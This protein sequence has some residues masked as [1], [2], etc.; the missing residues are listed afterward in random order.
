M[1]TY[2]HLLKEAAFTRVHLR[3]GD[4]KPTSTL[5]HNPFHSMDPHHV[6]EAVCKEIKSITSHGIF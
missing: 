4:K 5:P 2:H 6:R 3:H 1:G